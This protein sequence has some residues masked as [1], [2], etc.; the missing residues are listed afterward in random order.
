MNNEKLKIDVREDGIY[1]IVDNSDPENKA[2]R[3]DVLE[4]VE[5]YRIA[6]IDFDAVSAIFSSDEPHITK[7]I[8]NSTSINPKDET[9]ELDT[10]KDKMTVFGKFSPP[11]MGGKCLVSS[12][13]LGKLKQYGVV[14]GILEDEIAKIAESAGSKNYSEKFVLAQGKPAQNGTDGELTY[15][16]DISGE[17]NHP[18]ILR[19]GTVD[20]KQIEYFRSVKKGQIL[21][22]RGEPF[23]GEPGMTV[24]GRALT[25]KAGKIAPKFS[26]GKNVFISEDEK[27]LCAE[28]SGQLVYS[29]KTIGVT[30]I[31][32]IKGNVDFETGNID[33][34]GSVNVRGNVVSGF[35]IVAA[36]NVEVKG[37][38]EAASISA[39][40]CVNLYGGI[41]GLDRAAITAQGDLFTKFA[42]NARIMAKGN[43]ISNSLMHC[44][45][46]CE[47]SIL[48]QGDNCNIVGGTVSAREE[49]RAKT[50]GSPMA[51]KTL[52]RAGNSPE[53]IA[54]FEDIKKQYESAKK[55]YLQLNEGYESI[56][57]TG[58]VDNFDERRKSMLFKIVNNRTHYRELMMQHEQELQALAAAM[59][60]NTGKIIAE[61]TI[62]YGVTLTVGNAAMILNDDIRMGV[63]FVNEEDA[64]KMKTYAAI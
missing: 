48:L 35:S 60:R 63:V 26:K 29:G 19:D 25:H 20:Y 38:V 18:K 54:R 36:G 16:F 61:R 8:S 13:I 27:I 62:H 30:N 59:N 34:D 55:T 31:L 64:V 4:V 9:M 46:T 42:Q 52:V 44:E 21:A 10:D 39:G 45:I 3:K 43:I 14:Y 41:Q 22:Q 51:T 2:T 47:G 7:K 28:I 11:E 15:T 23:Y 58:N 37:V 50:I 12:E 1:I 5:K 24:F 33:F 57:K 56:M 6:N 49:I 17:H 53:L 40:G 32:E